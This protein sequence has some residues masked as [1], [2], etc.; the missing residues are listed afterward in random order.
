MRFTPALPPDRL[1]AIGRL[2]FGRFE[3]VALRFAEPFWREAGFPHMMVFPRDPEEWMVWVMGQDAFGGGP[4]LV[5]F[6]FHSAAERL[7]GAGTDASVRWALGMLA[8]AIGRPCPEPA[9][10]AVSSW[11]ADPWTGGAYTHIPP[12]ASPAD[13]DLLGEPVGGRLLFAGEHTQSAR[14]AY[15]DGALT[16]GIREAK[17]LLGTPAVRISVNHASKGD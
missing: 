13:A 10:V 15:A 7:A 5:F 17:R 3:K 4:V 6:V 14:L 11:A 12:G 8:E 16:S 1:A 2:G 9:V